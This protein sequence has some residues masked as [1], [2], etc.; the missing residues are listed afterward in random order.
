MRTCRHLWKRPGLAGCTTRPGLGE[1][2][3]CLQEQVRRGEKLLQPLVGWD[4]AELG[5]AGARFLTLQAQLTDFCRALAQRRQRL[6]DAERLLQLFRQVGEGS[7]PW[8]Q[9]VSEAR[10]AAARLYDSLGFV[11]YLAC[12]LFLSSV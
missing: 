3:L 5:P 8:L 7:H 10:G 4:A 9:A 12:F 2:S 6:A 1:L 11:V